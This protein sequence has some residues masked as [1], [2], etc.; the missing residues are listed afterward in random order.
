MK[1]DQALEAVKS[2][3]KNDRLVKH[4]LAVEAIMRAL[5]RRLGE[6]E[7]AWAIAGLVHDLDYDE[8]ANDPERHGILGASYLREMGVDEKIA[9][10][11]ESH[12]GHRN[13]ESQMDKAL[14]AID[15]LSGLLVAAALMHPA[16]KLAPVDADFVLNRFKEKRF[17]AGANREQIKTCEEMGISLAEFVDLGLKAMQAVSD[18]LG[19]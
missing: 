4:M 16:K 6:D 13:R 7:E 9:H 19:L 18:D 8:T 14:Y 10:A 15:P 17:A 2:R 11:V 1:R 5:A 12:A 3:V